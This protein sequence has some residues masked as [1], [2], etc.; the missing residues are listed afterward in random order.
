[1]FSKVLLPASLMIPTKWTTASIPS[2]AP[3]SESAFVTSPGQTS[4]RSWEFNSWTAFD[5]GFR[6]NTR[7]ECPASRARRTTS[8]PTKPLAPVMNRNIYPDRPSFCAFSPR[9]NSIS[10]SCQFLSRQH[11]R[12]P[13]LILFLWQLRQLLLHKTNQRRNRFA[14]EFEPATRRREQLRQRSRPAEPQR[15]L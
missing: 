2:R 6:A 5:F 9:L 13:R 1:M 7:T 3:R 12:N 8:R 14:A 4:V 15:R 10:V 11:P